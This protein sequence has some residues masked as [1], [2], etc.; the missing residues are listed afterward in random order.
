MSSMPIN[1]YSPFLL[2]PSLRKLLFCYLS[3]WVYLLWIFQ[4]NGIIHHL[5][6]C[7][8]L[9]SRSMMFSR[10]THAVACEYFIL[11]HGWILWVHHALFIHSPV[12]GHLEGSHFFHLNLDYSWSLLLGCG[13][14]QL[15]KP[16][17]TLY[18]VWI[19]PPRVEQH[20]DSVPNQKLSQTLPQMHTDNVGHLFF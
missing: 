13:I 20:S 9:L 15:Q 12:S 8:G 7:I 14:A 4:I 2:H 3:L 18:S 1:S 10:L 5:T 6:L 19:V 17:V 16:M 11:F